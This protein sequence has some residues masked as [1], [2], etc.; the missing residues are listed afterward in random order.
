[1][2]RWLS[3]GTAATATALLCA[4]FAWALL[5]Y[6]QPMTEQTYDLS[7][8]W[9]TE[10]MPD[11][12]VYDQKGWTACTQEGEEIVPLT[13]DGMG[14]FTGLTVPGQTVWFSRVMTE[15]VESPVLYLNTANRSVAV[16]LD[17]ERL[18]TDCPELSG[19]VGEL[20]LPM[21]G[22]DRTEP[23]AVSLPMDYA[24]K[25]L[26]IAQS[27]GLGEKQIPEAESTVYL[28]GVTLSC[29]YAYESG[30]IA[31]SFR[32]AIP[33]ALCFA[34]GL[35]LCAAFL[36]QGF[37]GRWD[38]GLALAALA[39][40]SLMLAPLADVSFLGRYLPYPQTDWNALSRAM[41]LTAL[42]VL[43]GER[44]SGRL[45]WLLWGMAA[46]HGTAA[47]LGRSAATSTLTSVSEFA[48]LL[49]L[50]AAGVLAVVWMKRENRFYRLFAPLFLAA[51][52]LGAAVWVVHTLAEPQWGRELLLQLRTGFQVGLPRFLLWKLSLPALGAGVLAALIHL[53][54]TEAERRTEARLLLQRGELAQ[55]NY[56]N[57]RRHSEELAS[58]RHDM[59]HHITA[60]QGLC[61]EGNMAELQTY[62]E[63]LAQ[64]PELNRSSGCTVHP[65]VDAVL[66]AMLARGAEAGVRSEVRVELPPKLSIP[67]SDLCPLLMNL[68][69]NALEANEKVPEGAD[70]WLR[71]TMHIRGEYLYIGVENARFGPVDFDPE[72]RLYRSTKSGAHHGMGLKSA[73]A[74]ARKYH[75]ELV[76]K[77]SGDAFSASTALL[78]PKTEA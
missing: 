56:E 77:S 46:L 66:T 70:K 65:A 38:V 35:L 19:G 6:T 39:V 43:L 60:L 51:L 41:C 13:P 24:G 63:T 16:F 50:L 9:T 75:S 34:L 26:T 28:C 29:G 73:R 36:W 5:F 59:R 22:W 67:D 57:L 12:W 2:R 42:L 62:L 8:G 71:V 3:Q 47:L 11:G 64:R 10:A 21:L 18:Y 76:L 40:F 78:L 52:G 53:F 23:V 33:A 74:T 68:L 37:R 1:M 55:E 32:A 25:T 4:F 58:L 69:E 48:G 54:Q 44:G 30:L 14:G 31:E 27:T 45:R 72:E 20:T 15:A 17:G 61:R 7:L 49:G